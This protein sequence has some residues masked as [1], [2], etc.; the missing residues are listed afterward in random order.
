MHCPTQQDPN[1][2]ETKS[3]SYLTKNV[4]NIDFNL[5]P[6]STADVTSR[7]VYH[8]GF[9]FSTSGGV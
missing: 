5:S 9:Q 2:T 4:V 7:V 1:K 6:V 8:S 3:C